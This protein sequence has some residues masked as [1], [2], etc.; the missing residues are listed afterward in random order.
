MGTETFLHLPLFLLK[1]PKVRM[2]MLPS[3]YDET[4]VEAPPLPLL[5]VPL[6]PLGKCLERGRILG[7]LTLGFPG[8]L[9][10]LF[11]AKVAKQNQTKPN[12][13]LS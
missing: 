4:P 5:R 9:E 3:N 2:K 6:Y 7:S 1:A 11:L 12:Q 8:L 10:Q 13:I